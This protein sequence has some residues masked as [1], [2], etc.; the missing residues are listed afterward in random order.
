MPGLNEILRALYGAYRLARFDAGGLTFFDATVGGFWRSFFAAVI[1]APLY[2]TMLGVRFTSQAIEATPARFLAIEMI[3]YVI[4]WV[5]YPLVMTTVVRAIDRERHY[6]RYMVAYNWAGVWQSL[7]YLP[8]VI[9]TYGGAVPERA[10][11]VP[12]LAA[13]LAILV[14]AWFIAR[15]GLAIPGLVAASLVALEVGLGLAITAIAD[16]LL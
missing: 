14:Y 11:A 16:R 10:V 6:L 13:F 15:V 2:V 1:V 9:L 8:L 5:A 12:T 7:L 3:S 4:G